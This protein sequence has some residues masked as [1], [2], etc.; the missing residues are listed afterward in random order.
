MMAEGSVESQR[1][2][3]GEFVDREHPRYRAFSQT[4]VSQIIR[5]RQAV[6]K[7]PFTNL[8]VKVYIPNLLALSTKI[9]YLFG[10]RTADNLNTHRKLSLG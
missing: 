10:K 6:L 8:T 1:V 5:D 7:G 4:D 3:R 9:H 2:L